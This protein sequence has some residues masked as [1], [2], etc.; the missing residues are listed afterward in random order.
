[1]N[2]LVENPSADEL[3]DLQPLFEAG[4]WIFGPEYEGIGKYTSN[5]S[6]STVI[7]KFFSKKKVKLKNPR[8][9]PDFVLL[10]DS[11]IGVYS[12]DDFDDSSEVDAINKVFIVELKKGGFKVSHKEKRQALDYA[13]NLF[14]S[15][16]FSSNDPKIVCCVLGAKIDHSARFP[17][18]EGENIIVKTK[19][20]ESVLRRASART[21]HLIR[22]IEETKGI[23]TELNDRE[24]KEVLEQ[25]TL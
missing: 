8:K 15:G 10:E 12:A 11:S 22:K 23:S 6:L 25:R 19:T 16:A 2:A 3:H 14:D 4:L 20:Y 5:N 18:K 9:R 24:I 17:S 21:H 7:K 1:M 13:L